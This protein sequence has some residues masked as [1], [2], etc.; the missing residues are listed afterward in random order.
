MSQQ[1]AAMGSLKQLPNNL[2]IKTDAHKAGE[3]YKKTTTC[4]L[5]RVR[6]LLDATV[7]LRIVFLKL[8]TVFLLP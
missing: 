6:K 3:G 4:L 5:P 7:I 8:W 1:S 2:K